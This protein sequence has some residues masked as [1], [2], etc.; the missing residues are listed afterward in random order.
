MREK[1][2]LAPGLGG[3][4]LLRS[5]ALHGINGIGMR[6]L[7]A[8]ELARLALMRSGIPVDTDFVSLREE[9]A[10]AAQAAEG[11]PYFGRPS[12]TDIRE[13]AAAIRRLR[14]LIT[15]EDEAQ[16]LA[17]KLSSGIF[18]EKNEALLRVYRRYMGI[19]ASRGAA[20][21]VTLIRRAAA[22]CGPI[23]ADFVILREYPLSP[24]ENL[25]L[26]RLSGG[27]F[28]ETGV[29]EL[30]GEVCRPLRIGAIR[31]C[32]GAPN[33]VETILADIYAG[34]RLDQCTVAVTDE[35]TYGQLFF[36][37]ALL[38]DIPVTFGCGIPVMNANPARLL[39]L[40][41]R[42]I[43]GGFYGAAAIGEMLESPAFDRAKLYAQFPEADDDFRWSTFYEVLGSL[44]LT[45]DPAVNRR[46]IADFRRAAA[47]EAAQVCGEGS[48]EDS[49]EASEVASTEA[50]REL[51]NIRRKQSCIPHLEI[52]ARELGLP[53]EEFI[54]KYAYIRRGTTTNAE[55]LTGLLDVSAAGAIYEELRVIGSCG[56]H[57][58]ADEIIPEVLK[59]MVCVQGSEPGKLHVTGIGGAFGTMRPHLYLAGMSASNFPGSPKENYLLLDADL[60]AFGPEAGRYT[61]DGRILQ[62]R[63]QLLSLAHL[64]S[65]L[66]TDI[67]VSYAGLNVSELKRDNA[68]SLIY[69]MLREAHGS[70]APAEEL[71]AHTVR[72]GYFEPAISGNRLIGEAYTKGFTVCESSGKPGDLAQ[73]VP[74]S[75][76]RAW[77]PTALDT[78]FGCPR[79]F[80][81]RYILGIP[82]PEDHDPFVIMNA[83]DT[84]T[85]AHALMERL[86]NSAMDR[87]AFL[88]LAEAY[89]E[90]FIREHPPLIP[91]NVPPVK[92][93]F[94]EMMETAFDMDPRREAVLEE[95][96]IR[97]T[98]ESGVAISGYPDRVEKLED[99]TYLIVDFKS[100][101]TAVHVQDDIG[102]C[103][104]VVLYAYLM[105]QRGYAVSGGEYRYIRLGETVTCRYDEEMKSRLSERL[106]QFKNS[107]ESGDFPAAAETEDGSDPCRYCMYKGICGREKEEGT[108][109]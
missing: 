18:A 104:Q 82:E 15:E 5:L 68:S 21:A 96:E 7:G 19:L 44:R 53:A 102:T 39:V 84:G 29:L 76:E 32:Y 105:E 90:R 25:L 1:I 54:A 97:C 56:R 17:E 46:R 100:G 71:E 33:E 2:I 93:Q 13:I 95:E 8:A 63:Q 64:A 52:M 108:V 61:A 49:T 14:S 45:N 55:R 81:L 60:R 78:F 24:L 42:W 103:L 30:F 69:E 86:G 62:K 4:E 34:K 38:F 28:S 65:A 99:G 47:E 22:E 77:S 50:S 16:A 43:T 57:R 27:V 26:R 101:R 9:A 36:D 92:A 87:E 31:N 94:L 98:H 12:W 79:R 10:I 75:A 91:E 72:V 58:S 70:G 83:L 20:D 3:S 35:L 40:Y 107:L 74:W 67:S 23:D 48:G 80:M 109:D 59:L 66:G 41:Y 6:V 89:F 11:E 73:P 51:R 106:T 88:A 85:L 37:Y